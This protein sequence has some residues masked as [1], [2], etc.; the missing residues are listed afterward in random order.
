MLRPLICAWFLLFG[1]SVP[2]VAAEVNDTGAAGNKAKSIEIQVLD[3]DGQALEGTVIELFNPAFL[4]IPE[5]QRSSAVM[6]QINKQF[7]P[8][9]LVVQ[10]GEMV[11]FPNSDSIKHHVYSFSKPKPFQLKLYKDIQPEPIQFGKA[12]VVALGCNIHDWMVGYI[13]V[14]D[15]HYVSRSD[16]QGK[17]TFSFSEPL[18]TASIAFSVWHPRMQREDIERRAVVHLGKSVVFELSQKLHPKLEDD[19]DEF[20]YQ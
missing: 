9:I 12:G 20:S 11:N 4:N 7:V 18:E 13:Y 8:H 3:S 6:D 5:V 10:R 19:V 15:S 14:A 17:V 16:K 2:V 1:P